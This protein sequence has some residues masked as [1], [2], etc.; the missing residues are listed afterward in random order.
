M[1]DYALEIW[2]NVRRHSVEEI[3]SKLIQKLDRFPS[4]K[5]EGEELP[6]N[7]TTILRVYS[8]D[9]RAISSCYNLYP[10]NR[11][12]LYIGRD[13][14]SEEVRVK[15]F[16]ILA[17]IENSLRH[18]I[19][20]SMTEVVGFEWWKTRMPSSIGQ[21]IE[22]IET[23]RNRDTDKHP[24]LDFSFFEDLV[25]FVTAKIQ[26][27]P[28]NKQITIADL[29][30]VLANSNSIE[31][32]KKLLLEY[33]K[34]VSLWDDV[35]SIY[36]DQEEKWKNLQDDLLTKVIPIRHK[37]V[38]HR[39]FVQEYEVSQIEDIKARLV[40]TLQTAKPKLSD[41]EREIAKRKA[42]LI[43]QIQEIISNLPEE[44]SE[45][46][47]LHYGLVDN[48]PHSFDEIGDML[49]ISLEEV[50]TQH[51]EALRQLRHPTKKA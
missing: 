33:Q 18:F 2:V 31:E 20:H 38:H 35:F 36:F 28:D 3:K 37:V 49:G 40:N 39:G 50:E 47:N 14:L 25:E 13:D 34:K 21:R 22:E 15:A 41:Q 8:E 48:R 5:I 16:P 43:G 42:L 32:L 27:W 51:L 44:M 23:R 12:S 11:N 4:I 30:E 10:W 29:S 45:I 24:P 1:T 7:D 19:N 6:N 17:D 9:S 26:R 46:I